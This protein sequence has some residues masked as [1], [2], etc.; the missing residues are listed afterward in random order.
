MGFA[1]SCGYFQPLALHLQFTGAYHLVARRALIQNPGENDLECRDSRPGPQLRMAPLASCRPRAR[2]R[3]FAGNFKQLLRCYDSPASPNILAFSTE[4][5]KTSESPPRAGSLI[6]T[7]HFS[8]TS[9]LCGSNA[10]DSRRADSSLLSQCPERAHWRAEQIG[11][12]L[13]E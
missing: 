8:P 6:G 13:L 10:G 11:Q 5:L 3:R 2:T 1:A 9:L 12:F 7:F 4:Q